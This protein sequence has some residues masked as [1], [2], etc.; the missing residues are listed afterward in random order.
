VL[1]P[2][3]RI[4][5]TTIADGEANTAIVHRAAGTTKA[6]LGIEEHD[7]DTL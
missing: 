1:R 6:A 3:T 7:V 4:V 2:S 5:L